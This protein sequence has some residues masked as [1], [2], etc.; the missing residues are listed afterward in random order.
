[1]S[2]IDMSN[3][4]DLDQLIDEATGVFPFSPDEP[5]Q[6]F[7]C[8]EKFVDTD[9]AHRNAPIRLPCSGQHVGCRSCIEEWV[10]NCLEND[11]PGTCGVCREVVC[12]DYRPDAFEARID[13]LAVN[14][15]DILQYIF[16]RNSDV[17]TSMID[18]MMT[19]L[20]HVPRPLI[21]F[22]S[23]AEVSENSDDPEQPDEPEEQLAEPGQRD[24]N[25][26]DVC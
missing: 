5:S 21:D 2:L 23:L 22:R 6:C 24:E 7:V 16:V 25:S 26:L 11:T 19:M 4:P 18:E 17:N 12:K 1:M 14:M 3:I 15:V 9:P 13:G 20:D 10:L 8:Y